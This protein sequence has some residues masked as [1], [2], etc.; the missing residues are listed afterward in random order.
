MG[1]SVDLTG[2]APDVDAPA[3]LYGEDGARAVL[4]CPQDVADALTAL[5]EDHGVPCRR[6]GTVGDPGAAVEVNLDQ[7]KLRWPSSE[8]RR[9]YFDAIPRRMERIQANQSEGA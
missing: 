4:S 9:R 7:E 8:L 6:I 1:V 5:A 3:L 2:Y